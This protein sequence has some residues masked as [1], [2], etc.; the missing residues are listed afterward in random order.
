MTRLPVEVRRQA[1][2][3]A[4]IRVIAREG[5]PA[6]TTRAIVAEA[7]MS[8]ASFHYAF[9]SRDELLETVIAHVT[10][11]EYAAVE[12]GYLPIARAIGESV[13]MADVVLAGL[14]SYLDL[15]I[16][17]PGREQAM[18]E[19]SLYALRTPAVATMVSVQYEHYL[20]SAETALVA[21]A[22]ATHHRWTIPTRE[23]A[24]LLVTHT[25]GLTTTWLVDRDSAAARVSNAHTA[26]AIARFAEPITEP[27]TEPATLP[28]AAT[29]T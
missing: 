19:L 3:E 18:I 16:A 26:A 9:A 6:A 2:M 17:D 10:A 7:S 1:L 21:A 8:L 20:D 11:Q 23:A 15:L 24:R 12:A 22:A 25:D 28:I 13:T 27:I 5:V 4:A 14:N 29:P